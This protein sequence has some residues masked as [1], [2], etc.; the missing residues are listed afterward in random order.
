MAWRDAR[1]WLLSQDT[2]ER[3]FLWLMSL[4]KLDPDA[5]LARMD[6]PQLCAGVNNEECEA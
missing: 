1:D 4:L 3:T 5:V 6:K 2:S